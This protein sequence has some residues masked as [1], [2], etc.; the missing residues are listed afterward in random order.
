[1]D[2]RSAQANG[3]HLT[4]MRSYFKYKKVYQFFAIEQLST[5]SSVPKIQ[6]NKL[7]QLN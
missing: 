6:S 3:I 1:M 5:Q 7:S 2:L 4:G